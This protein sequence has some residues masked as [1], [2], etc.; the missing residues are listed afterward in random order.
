[1]EVSV[2]IPLLDSPV[3]GQ[4]VTALREQADCADGFEVIVV[5][6]D[7]YGQVRDDPDLHFLDTGRPVPP[8]VARNR[9]AALSQGQWLLFLDADAIPSP[10][11]L[12]TLLGHLRAGRPI[13]SGAVAFP[14]S[15][16]WTWCDN[17]SAFHE[18]FPTAPP[19]LR[20]YL[21]TISLGLDRAVWEEI[22]PFDETFTCAEDIALTLR[23]Y[24]AGYPLYF[25]PAALLCHLPG[26]ASLPAIL[27][28]RFRAGYEMIDLRRRFH[29]ILR[30]P[31]FLQ[32]PLLLGL[33]S[34]LLALAATLYPYR[35]HSH[36][37]HLPTIPVVWLTKLAW[38]AGALTRLGERPRYAPDD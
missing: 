5:G 36:W 2:V 23:A 28:R 14:R 24:C 1:M 6:R 25:E 4:A 20:R 15:N 35:A 8:A 16:Y 32:N 30:T 26:R 10:G 34:P 22:G 12:A 13:V 7:G 38:C 27:R 17:V 19:G 9:G 33:L 37:R 31:L 11:W 29:H 18:F 21:P 3:I